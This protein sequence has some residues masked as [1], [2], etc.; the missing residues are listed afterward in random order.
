[1]VAVIKGAGSDVLANVF[2]VPA[3][4]PFKDELPVGVIDPGVMVKFVTGNVLPPLIK[5]LQVAVTL[6]PTAFWRWSLTSIPF[7]DPVVVLLISGKLSKF[8]VVKLTEPGALTVRVPA[9]MVA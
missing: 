1:L 4:T 3:L 9:V 8:T 7:I 2:T 5:L 6:Q